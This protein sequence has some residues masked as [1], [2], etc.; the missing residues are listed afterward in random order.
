MHGWQ[1]TRVALHQGGRQLAAE[2]QLLRPIGVGHDA[3]EQLHALYHACFDL[4]PVLV[5]QHERKQVE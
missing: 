4:Q 1:I 3:F 5:L 2:H